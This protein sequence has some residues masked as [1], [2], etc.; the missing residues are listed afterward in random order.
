M[1]TIGSDYYAVQ[2]SVAL[3]DVIAFEGRFFA[4]RELARIMDYLSS[5]TVALNGLWSA[6]AHLP[7]Q[8][9]AV[10]HGVADDPES[11]IL[12]RQER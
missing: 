8:R 5:N 2:H 3:N 6:I 9:E 10:W 11:E 12:F 7:I 1:D 4:L